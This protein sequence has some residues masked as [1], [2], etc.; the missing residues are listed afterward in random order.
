MR[1]AI[2][3]E[4][5]KI[6]KQKKSKILFALTMIASLLIVIGNLYL[7]SK[8]GF[9]VV[10]SDRMSLS[11]IDI[12]SGFLLPL[13]AFIMAVDSISSEVGTG[14]VKYGFMAPISRKTYLGSK[15]L[16]LQ[17]YN[18]ALLAGVFLISFIGNIFTMNGSI[19]L[20]FITGLSAYAITL[21]PMA[22]VSLWGLLIGMHFSSG[23]SLGVG[24]I[25]VLGLNIAGVFM[26]VFGR[27]S[28]LEYMD[29]YSN[30]LYN[31]TSF[32]TL[33]SVLLYLVSYY[34]IL[35][36]LNLIRINQKEI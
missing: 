12:L 28:P 23:L 3:I 24:L 9:M 26:P 16:A 35:I 33:V 36:A 15:L 11:M 19:V 22:L 34:I 18:G 8:A 1:K 10:E 25:G 21:I 14:T 4:W 13:V 7:G 20:N 31:N 32:M 30:V 6:R 17:I 2:E 27:V 29:L 5:L